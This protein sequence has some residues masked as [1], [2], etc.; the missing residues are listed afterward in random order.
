MV[1]QMVLVR[2]WGKPPDYDQREDRRALKINMSTMSPEERALLL[3]LPRR[4]LPVPRE[5]ELDG[6]PQI[7]ATAGRY[8]AIGKKER[9]AA[10][11]RALNPPVRL[12]T[13]G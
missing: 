8:M 12:K 9:S 1:A 10:P 2:S 11:S 13:A 6:V 3:G 5:P 4:G 7:N